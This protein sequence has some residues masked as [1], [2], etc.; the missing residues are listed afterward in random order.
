MSTA[1]GALHGSGWIL[2]PVKCAS[3]SDTGKRS[4]CLVKFQYGALAHRIIIRGLLPMVRSPARWQTIIIRR[5]DANDRRDT[6]AIA[7]STAL[8][9]AMAGSLMH[10]RHPL[11][12]RLKR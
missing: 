1:W 11:C 12:A 8:T 7:I 2:P 6:Q 10:E 9:F 5:A 4:A 3:R